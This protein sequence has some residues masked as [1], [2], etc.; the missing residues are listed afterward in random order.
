MSSAVNAACDVEAGWH[1]TRYVTEIPLRLER[2]EP[3]P[4]IEALFERV[5]ARSGRAGCERHVRSVGAVVTDPASGGRLGAGS[6]NG[7]PAAR[8]ERP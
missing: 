3:D 2:V 5:I 6:R 4:F 8:T 1:D 7:R